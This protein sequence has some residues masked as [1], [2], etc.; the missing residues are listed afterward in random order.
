M[1]SYLKVIFLSKYKPKESRKDEKVNKEYSM[2]GN[3]VVCFCVV[4]YILSG[5]KQKC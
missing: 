5:K 1:Q 3:D 2:D 4:F